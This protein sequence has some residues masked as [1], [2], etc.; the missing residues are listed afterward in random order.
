MIDISRKAKYYLDLSMNTN[1]NIGRI[2]MEMY[3]INIKKGLTVC[4][5]NNEE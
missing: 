4:S 2:T 5:Q 1:K 3:Q